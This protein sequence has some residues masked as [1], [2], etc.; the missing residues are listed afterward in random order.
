MRHVLVSAGLAL[1]VFG[2]VG[3]STGEPRAAAPSTGL[4]PTRQRPPVQRQARDLILAADLEMDDLSDM[5]Y[6]ARND[7]FRE[8]VARQ[9]AGIAAWRERLVA[10]VSPADAWGADDKRVRYDMSN[11]EQAM[12]AGATT[13]PQTRPATSGRPFGEYD[14]ESLPPSR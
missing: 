1:V 5:Q 13:R 9:I 8:A 12:R 6:H 7:G 10:D 3:C 2:V 11:L 4:V 14:R